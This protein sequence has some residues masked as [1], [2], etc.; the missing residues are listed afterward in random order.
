[1]IRIAILIILASVSGC[2][3]IPAAGWVAIG[4]VAGAVSSV[5]QLDET[6][7]DAYLSMKG[8]TIAPKPT[9]QETK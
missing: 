5:A 2:A 8:K 9:V 6:A 3:A 4:A 1:V 7:I